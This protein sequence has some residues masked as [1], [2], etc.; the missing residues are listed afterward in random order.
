MNCSIIFSVN[1]NLYFFVCMFSS[2]V[3]EWV[4]VDM[5]WVV[6]IHK[7]VGMD[8]VVDIHK[9]VDLALLS[10]MNFVVVVAVVVLM[11]MFAL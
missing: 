6:D 7:V 10:L 4:I 8:W 1:F 3:R 9:V 5:D 2:V 11:S